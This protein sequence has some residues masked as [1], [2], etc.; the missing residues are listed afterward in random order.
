M[1]GRAANRSAALLARG[2]GGAARRALSR[3]VGGGGGGRQRAGR[4]L[5]APTRPPGPVPAAMSEEKPK[6]SSARRGGGLAGAGR[7]AGRA[8]GGEGRAWPCAD[9]R[10]SGFSPQ[11]GVKTENDHINLKV[12][13]QDGSVVQFKIKRHTPL[14]KLMKAYCERQVRASPRRCRGRP[15]PCAWGS[16]RWGEARAAGSGQRLGLAAARGGLPLL[17]RSEGSA[18]SRASNAAWF[19][20][21]VGSGR[22]WEPGRRQSGVR[23]EQ[24]GSGS[25]GCQVGLKPLV[26]PYEEPL[27]LTHTHSM[28][29]CGSEPAAALCR[30]HAATAAAAQHPSSSPAPSLCTAAVTWSFP[31]AYIP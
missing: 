26:C 18:P 7:A 3:A 23:R 30:A 2:G 10:S 6:V 28:G 4:A 27:A 17:P 16:A 21:C 8:G 29:C 22:G 5:P 15:R 20:V 1:T 31:Y 12:A 13:G 19:R 25:V 11:E 9:L 24:G 14:S